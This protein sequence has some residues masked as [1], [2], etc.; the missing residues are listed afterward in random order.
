MEY[1]YTFT[2]RA[3]TIGSA[4]KGELRF[5][6]MTKCFSV[7]MEVIHNLKVVI[8]AYIVFISFVLINMIHTN[9]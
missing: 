3:I 9:L 8:G 5:E 4:I 2:I 1:V 7:V 6:P